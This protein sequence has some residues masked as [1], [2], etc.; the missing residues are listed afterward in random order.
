MARALMFKVGTESLLC[1]AYTVEITAGGQDRMGTMRTV[2]SC[3]NP[4]TELVIGQD[5]SRTTLCA[6]CYDVIVANPPHRM[7]VQRPRNN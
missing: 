4:A 7:L 6:T 2:G 5:G 1:A 3:G